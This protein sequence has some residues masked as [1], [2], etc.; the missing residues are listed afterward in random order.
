MKALVTG[1]DGFVGEHLLAHLLEAGDRVT[2]SSLSLPPNRAVL[3]PEQAGAVEWKVADVLDRDAL[4]RLVA[5]VRPEHV[6]HLAG[7]ASGAEARER[8]EAAVRVNAGGTVNLFEAVVAAR[9][10]FPGLEPRVL[11]LGSGDAYGDAGREGE[12]LKEERPLRPVTPYG[13]SKACQEL[14]THT[15]RRAH[16]VDALVIRAFNLIG[17]GQKRR[18]V[19]PDF[20]AQVAAIAAGKAE[21]VLRVGDLEVERDF[22]DVRD[23]V[24]AFRA[25]LELE[26]PGRAYNVC[27]G[28]AVSIGTALRWILDEAGLEVEVQAEPERVREG[29]LPRLAGDSEAVRRDTGWAPTRR[30]E[31]TVRET[32]RWM[33]EAGARGSELRSS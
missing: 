3:A 9:G 4:Y 16:G 2:A 26:E 15:Y 23:A 33:V 6:Y 27:S 24:R 31:E 8:P 10:D 11:V 28:E 7:F 5:A 30:P 13:L 22:T 21:P 14:V 17:P 1:G 12:K 25:V 32:Y 20:C 29:E 18:F 19:I